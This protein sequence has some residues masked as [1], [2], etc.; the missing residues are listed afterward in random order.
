M[1]K[2]KVTLILPADLVERMVAA[3]VKR[4]TQQ[5]ILDTITGAGVDISSVDATSYLKTATASITDAALEYSKCKLEVLAL[6]REKGNYDPLK[7]T[8]IRA[9]S[10]EETGA[11]TWDVTQ[12]DEGTA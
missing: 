6:A 11:V 4:D 9:N 3:E 12:A 10:L 8:P 2:K 1:T 5:G 7:C